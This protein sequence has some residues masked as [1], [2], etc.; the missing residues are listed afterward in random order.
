MLD[1]TLAAYVFL[2]FGMVL[3]VFQLG[4]VLGASYGEMAMGG[5]IKGRFPLKLRI[6]AFV[7]MVLIVLCIFIVLDKASLFVDG[8]FTGWAIWLVVLLFAISLVLNSIT[9]SKKERLFGVPMT[10]IL[11][12]SSLFVALNVM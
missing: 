1:T 8:M 5:K 6:A 11:F 2:I 7:Q 9:S 12:G 4:L 10:A 3:V